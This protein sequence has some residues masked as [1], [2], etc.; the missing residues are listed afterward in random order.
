THCRFLSDTMADPLFNPVPSTFSRAINTLA[1]LGICGVLGMAFFDQLVNNELPC[2]LCLLQRMAFMLI[3][4]GL[5]LNIRF[6]P[7]PMHYGVILLSSLVGAVAS[8][9][10]VLLHLAP[11][12]PGYGAPFMGLH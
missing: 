12:D 4:M 11:G 1:L 8:G 7:S 3:G 6:G 5:L 2:P 10:Q 9:R